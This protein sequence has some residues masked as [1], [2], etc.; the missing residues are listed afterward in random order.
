MAEIKG[1]SGK[2]ALVDDEG[3]LSV[4]SVSEPEDKHINREGGV[5]SAYFMETPSGSDNYFFYLKNTGTSDLF[6]T[7]VRI[8]STVPTTVYYEFVSGGPVFSAESPITSTNRNLGATNTVDAVISSDPDVTG[9]VSNGILFFEKITAADTRYKLSTTST[10]IIPQGKSVAFRS[11][12]AGD[13][14]CVVSIVDG[15]S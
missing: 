11:L 12:V 7:D 5:H 15:V 14:E 1:P 9:L 4:F 13:I 2:V 10:I 3:R 8:S 6:L